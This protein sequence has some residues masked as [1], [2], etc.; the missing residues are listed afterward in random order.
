[1]STDL[2]TTSYISPFIEGKILRLTEDLG[3][4]PKGTI[5][6]CIVDLGDEFIVRT[7]EVFWGVQ[8]FVFPKDRKKLFEPC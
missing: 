8:E 4:L 7:S 3:A 2:Q 1:M 5:V 6:F